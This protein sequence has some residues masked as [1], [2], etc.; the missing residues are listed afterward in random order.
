[1]CVFALG[2]GLRFGQGLMCLDPED[3]CGPIPPNTAGTPRT[4]RGRRPRGARPSRAVLQNNE[5]IPSVPRVEAA[6]PVGGRTDGRGAT[7]GARGWSGGGRT[8]GGSRREPPG[9]RRTSPGNTPPAGSPPS[10]RP[11]PARARC[12]GN[13]WP[14]TLKKYARPF[15][16]TSQ[17]RAKPLTHSPSAIPRPGRRCSR[18]LVPKCGVPKPGTPNPREIV[19]FLNY[20]LN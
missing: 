16:L 18:E 11:P 1:M 8:G 7:A 20:K 15:S 5:D 3:K 14:S 6:E 19:C 4:D 17:P 9:G 13:A 2:V 12:P 10:K